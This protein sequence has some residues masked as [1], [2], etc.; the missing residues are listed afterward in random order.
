MKKFYTCALAVAVA[1]GASAMP[2]QVKN[3]TGKVQKLNAKAKN[4]TPL[5][6]EKVSDVVA[7]NPRTATGDVSPVEG[8]YQ[9]TIGDFYFQSSQGEYK[10]TATV[11][12]DG[13]ELTISCEEFYTDV[14]ASYDD[15]TGAITFTNSPMFE[16][17]N[18]SNVVYSRFEPF[19][20][21]DS[22]GVTPAS[23]SATYAD[24]VI[25][26]PADHGFSWP[27]YPTVEGGE[28]LGYFRL[29]DVM[30]MV[31]ASNLI[32]YK[33]AEW[34][35]N[36][37]TGLFNGT[38]ATVTP[39]TVDVEY[40]KVT[41]TYTIPDAFH[42]TFVQLGF[43]SVS[44][45]MEI[46]CSNP[47]A[48][49]IDLTRTGISG[50]DE[51]GAYYV[52]SIYG[53]VE[54]TPGDNAIKCEKTSETIVITIPVRSMFLYASK[55]GGLSYASRLNE[56]K[57]VIN[58]EKSAVGNIAV[59]NENA[60]VKYYNLQGVEVANPENGLFIKVQGKKTSKVLVK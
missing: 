55:T 17:L 2:T 29:F 60:P 5:K 37:L 35:E 12:L 47:D 4:F 39:Q 6:M 50:G 30:G 23:F 36:I 53:L 8:T 31:N 7:T 59:E 57:L 33:S 18:G 21:T 11:L 46:N 32:T 28:S 16:T 27:A 56:S 43:N 38:S 25:Q 41:E 40:N 45:A 54:D 58:L 26:F 14:V 13:T 3:F 48:C 49:T 10:A 52:G 15:A 20:Y 24:G 34:T 51:D 22:E 9:I 44:P 42:S 1:L 19:A